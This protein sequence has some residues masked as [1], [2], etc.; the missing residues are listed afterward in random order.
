MT[1]AAV[2]EN[3]PKAPVLIGDV[4]LA[5]LGVELQL[6]STPEERRAEIVKRVECEKDRLILALERNPGLRGRFEYAQN[7]LVLEAQRQNVA[8][9]SA[10]Y[11]ATA[12]EQ[13]KRRA[14]AA[15]RP[16]RFAA[17]SADDQLALFAEAAA[18]TDARQGWKAYREARA[19]QAAGQPIPVPWTFETECLDLGSLRELERQGLVDEKLVEEIERRE[20]REAYS[21]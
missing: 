14:H 7:L 17:L 3:R 5:Q 9:A 19:L 11:A 10:R 1:A 21:W 2:A 8:Q 12:A 6:E 16:A 18:A 15:A 20:L 4:E 13:E